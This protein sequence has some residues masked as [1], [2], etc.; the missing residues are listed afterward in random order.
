MITKTARREPFRTIAI[1]AEMEGVIFDLL[2]NDISK[3]QANELIIALRGLTTDSQ[4]T[5]AFYPVALAAVMEW[6]RR[7]FVDLPRLEE[8]IKKRIAKKK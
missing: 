8:D 3:K 7:G 1:S 2:N 5:A 4:N 6:F